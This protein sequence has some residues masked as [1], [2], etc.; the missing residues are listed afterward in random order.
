MGYAIP[1]GLLDVA[2]GFVPASLFPSANGDH[3]WYALLIG[4]AAILGHVYTPFMK[5]RGG[6]GVATAAG[7]VL[8]VSPLPLLVSVTAWIVVLL[9][10]GYVSLASIAGAVT[11]PVAAWVLVPEKPHLLA[12]GVLI[13][14]FITFTHRVNL[15][16]LREGTESRFGQR[17]SR[18]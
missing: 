15:Q 9:V 12:I 6:K 8:A 3:A 11:F 4:T 1:V 7:V 2:K 5:F 14:A 17:V 16:R 10:S 13:A 18:D